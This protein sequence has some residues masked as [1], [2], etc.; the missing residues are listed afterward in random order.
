MLMPL[1]TPN[2]CT[3]SAMATEAT[4]LLKIRNGDVIAAVRS[5]PE[6]GIDLD[7]MTRQGM[8]V[9]A[10][11]TADVEDAHARLEPQDVDDRRD[12]RGGRYGG[13]EPCAL[14]Q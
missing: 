12:E 14:D 7:A 8:S 1:T 5:N 2:S 4:H 6:L 3:A 13:V 11:A 9:A 10:G